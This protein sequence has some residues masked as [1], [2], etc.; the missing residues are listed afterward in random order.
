M[1]QIWWNT[2]YVEMVPSKINALSLTHTHIYIMCILMSTWM[3]IMPVPLERLLLL[4][5]IPAEE[6][7][8]NRLTV[9][10]DVD[11]YFIWYNARRSTWSIEAGR[12]ICVHW[13]RPEN[14]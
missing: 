14:R 9:A 4:P 3:A 2:R 10:Y 12:L 13:R 6:E 11:G 5:I 7:F 8:N 1:S